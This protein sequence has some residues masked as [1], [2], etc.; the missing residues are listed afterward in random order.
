MNEMDSSNTTLFDNIDSLQRTLIA[1]YVL[2]LG[3]G[4]TSS[5]EGL[6]DVFIVKSILNGLE[7]SEQSSETSRPI[8]LYRIWRYIVRGVATNSRTTHWAAE[9]RG[10][11]YETFRDEEYR[12]P[13]ERRAT[14]LMTTEEDWKKDQQRKVVERLHVGTTALNNSQIASRGKIN[15]SSERRIAADQF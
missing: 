5:Q 15:M 13:W 12:L 4:N 6:A 14:I 1:R 2:G 10:D 7:D 3:A 9:I 11:L 8:W